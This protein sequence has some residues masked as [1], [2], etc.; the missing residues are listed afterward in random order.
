MRNVRH[1]G[2]AFGRATLNEDGS[3]L[4]IT[5]NFQIAF[6]WALSSPMLFQMPVM[7]N[8]LLPSKQEQLIFSNTLGSYWH[9]IYI[10]TAYTWPPSEMSVIS[11]LS[12]GVDYKLQSYFIMQSLLHH[13]KGFHILELFIKFI[14]TLCLKIVIVYFS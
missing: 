9:W 4:K 8:Y 2:L 5:K 13:T 3:C 7:L 1:N 10:A 6:W 11:K 12:F 14:F